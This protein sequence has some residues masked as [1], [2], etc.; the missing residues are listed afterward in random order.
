[1][2]GIIWFLAIAFGL[3]WI[4]WEIVIRSGVPVLGAQFQ[5]LAL[6]GAFAPAI[7]AFAV[8]KWITREGFADAGLALHLRSWRFYLL[9]WLMPLAVVALIIVQA[10]AFGIAEPDFTLER[11][12]ATEIVGSKAAGLEGFAWLVVPQALLL[13]IVATPV[14]WGEEFGWRGWLQRRILVGRPVAAAVV[15]GLI[16]A[17]WH[18]PLT[19]RGYNFPEQPLLGSL[20]FVAM[21]ILTSYL[22]GWFRERS[23]SIWAASL[24]HSAT[25]AVGGGLTTLWFAGGAGLHVVGYAGLLAI[26]PLF[27]VCAL[28]WWW[29]RRRALPARKQGVIPA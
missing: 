2:R 6:P 12:A 24:A 11:A 19:L 13:A 7:A 25:N 8:R 26:P 22:F 21:T 14:L 18:F 28:V 29:E 20:V 23:G 10:I 3:A 5:L 4:S 9:A 16:W 15:T 27:A 17:V 1:M